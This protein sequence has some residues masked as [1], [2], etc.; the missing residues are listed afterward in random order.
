MMELDEKYEDSALASLLDTFAYEAAQVTDSRSPF[1]TAD[2]W[3]ACADLGLAGLSIPR[4]YG[5]SGLGFT[6]TARAV[7]A[8]S[9]ECSD[10]GLTFAVLA[11]LFACAMPIAEH[12]ST[13]LR[14]TYLPSMASGQIVGANAITEEKA[15]SDI[16]AIETTAE[17]TSTGYLLTGSKSFV[18]NGPVADMFLVY[19]RTRPDFGHLGISAFVVDRDT[20]GLVVGEAMNKVGLQRCPASWIRFDDCV[21]PESSMLGKQGQGLAIFQS[22]MRWERTCLFAAYLG[23]S[24]R[25]L[26]QSVT[27]VRHRK[28]FGRPLAANQAVSHRIAR[29]KVRLEASRSLLDRACTRLDRGE[30][31]ATDVAIAKLAV[32]ENAVQTAFDAMHLFGG[33]GV[34]TAAGI[35][36]SLRDALPCT[37]FSGTSEMQL[38][39]IA[40]ELGL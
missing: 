24:E 40:M 2:E 3:L 5:G 4:Q 21:V 31:T 18:S 26:E 20:A 22:S 30:A 37:T 8:F 16:A 6:D 19:A 9:R 23:Q 35:E 29:M 36:Q 7:T 14:E 10:M 15:G 12:G 17:K 28:Q 11:H 34:R 13:A 27:H 39:Q 33:A 38:E 25:L 1:F 32:S